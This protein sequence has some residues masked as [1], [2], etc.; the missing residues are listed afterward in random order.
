MYQTKANI[1]RLLNIE[2]GEISQVQE[3]ENCLYVKG[4]VKGKGLSRFVSKQKALN[5]FESTRKERAKNL[6]VK[7]LGDSLF[8]VKNPENGNEYHV[9]VKDRRIHCTCEDYKKQVQYFG[10][11]TCKHIYAVLSL[12]E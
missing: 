2:P 7:K 3:W 9:T 6:T 5:M 10:V 11:G 1:A 12:K 8:L 4:C